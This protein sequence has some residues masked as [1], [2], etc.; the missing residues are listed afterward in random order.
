MLL[1]YVGGTIFAIW[2]IF[3]SNGLD[4]RLLAFGSMLPLLIDLPFG[5]QHAGHSM[6]G[7]VV[8]L[9]LV[10]VVTIGRGN[11]LRRRRLIGLPI[12]W[13]CGI[14]LSGAFTNDH[15]FWW[16]LFGVNVGNTPLLPPWKVVGALEVIGAAFVWWCISRFGLRSTQRRRELLRHGR[17]SIQ[18]SIADSIAKP[19]VPE[20]RGD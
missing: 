1:W 10:M 2:N 11:T 8:A 15:A 9:V 20:M 14:A 16:P 18:D 12:G 13:M 3:Q 19:L 7:A 5:A 4:T 6:L 17:V